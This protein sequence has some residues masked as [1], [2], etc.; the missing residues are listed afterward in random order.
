MPNKIEASG[1]SKLLVRYIRATS[2]QN[3][4]LANYD[5]SAEH[6]Q[7]VM[8]MAL[9]TEEQLTQALAHLET[10]ELIEIILMLG[11]NFGDTTEEEVNDRL[12]TLTLQMLN[13]YEGYH[14]EDE[15]PGGQFRNDPDGQDD[16]GTE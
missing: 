6:D 2:V 1:L 15:L 12:I 16:S 14:D 13:E 9:L 8:D 10:E 5:W 4:L 7:E 11:A 3:A